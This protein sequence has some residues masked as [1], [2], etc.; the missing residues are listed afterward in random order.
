MQS[1]SR[2]PH[3]ETS[4]SECYEVC[5]SLT[6]PCWL[7]AGLMQEHAECKGLQENGLPAETRRDGCSV[8]LPAA[9]GVVDATRVHCY[10]HAYLVSLRRNGVFA[11]RATI[12]RSPSLTCHVRKWPGR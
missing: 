11:A 6:V 10:S 9:G 2:R 5:I 1:K 4:L 8:Q 3:V 7:S 12:P